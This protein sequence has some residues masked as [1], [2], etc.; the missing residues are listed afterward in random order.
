MTNPSWITCNYDRSLTSGKE[1]RATS[2]KMSVFMIEAAPGRSC[3]VTD[4]TSQ[5]INASAGHQ[6]FGPHPNSHFTT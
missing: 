5:L 1:S 3:M 6:P 2:N 4:I